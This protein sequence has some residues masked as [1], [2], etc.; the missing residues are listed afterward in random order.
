VES[1]TYVSG[2]EHPDALPAASVA[3][4]R[5]EVVELSGTE[6]LMPGVPNTAV[7]ALAIGEPVQA[8]VVY[9]FTTV[10]A[11]AFPLT[12]GLLSL[13]GEAGFVPVI[14]G[15]GG[16]MVSTVKVRESVGLTLPGASTALT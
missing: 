2:G 5:N 4:A 1:S 10:P 9:S 8:A 6:T 15:V 13:A 7:E 14:F 3:V 12:L 11:A 16:G